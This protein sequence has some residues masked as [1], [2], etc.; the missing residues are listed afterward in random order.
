MSD[1]RD[2]FYFTTASARILDYRKYITTQLPDVVFTVSSSSPD[3]TLLVLPSSSIGVRFYNS[4]G[5]EITKDT[6]LGLRF[7]DPY[8]IFAKID[9]TKFDDLS[10]GTFLEFP[11]KF[12]LTEVPNTPGGE[13]W[14]GGAGAGPPIGSV[15]PLVYNVITKE[16]EFDPE[17]RSTTVE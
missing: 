5:S 4:A 7:N 14:S 11:I 10:V 17:D 13:A 9:V 1:I 8:Q 2:K 15:S 6:K 16:Y 12:E 3:T